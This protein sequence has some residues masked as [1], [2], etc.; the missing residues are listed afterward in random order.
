MD[1]L[2]HMVFPLSDRSYVSLVKKEI[3]KIADSI[4]FEANKLAEIEI[5][6]S[7]IT[8]NI[9]KH[10]PGGI[11]LVKHIISGDIEGLEIISIDDGPGMANPLMML[12]DGVSTTN[13]LG[14]GLGA[15][16]RLSDNFDIYSVP[17]WGTILLS[18]TFKT[19]EN[20]LTSNETSKESF[21]IYTLMVPK[22]GE[23][24]CG[25]GFK[26]LKKND[27]CQILA[28]DGLG[29]GPEAYKASEAAIKSFTETQNLAPAERLKSIHSS[30]K[31]TRGGVGMVF[32][33]DLKNETLSFCGV[34][35]I[36][37]RVLT[38][39]RLKSCISYNG[40]VGHTFP[41]TIHSNT[42][43]W[44]MDDYLIITSDGIISRWDINALANIRKHDIGI[45]AAILFKDFSR[46]ND[47]CLVMIIKANRIIS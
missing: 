32:D 25:D 5:I 28:F 21:N 15:I 13:T 42:I 10:T 39:G 20:I 34:G 1:N 16:K 27:N 8:S 12:R 47:D 9:I 46:G 41:N 36:S 45:I 18:R 6:I 43:S 37:A 2:P 38:E 29:H 19:T 7:E 3:K 35:N 22:K 33:F 11:I 24:F 40:I 30:I 14:Q 23:A 44:S 26:F 4:G 17:K 31:K